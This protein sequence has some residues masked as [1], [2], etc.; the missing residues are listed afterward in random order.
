MSSFFILLN[1]II[2]L[3]ERTELYFLQAS[4]DCLKRVIN[5]K[6]YH[7]LNRDKIF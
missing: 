5:K 6:T 4:A 3:I 1:L 2:P 7:G